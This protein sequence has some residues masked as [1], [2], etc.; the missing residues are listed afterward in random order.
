[1]NKQEK[2]QIYKIALE[3]LIVSRDIAKNAIN[4]IKE[5]GPS[6]ISFAMAVEHLETA[7]HLTSS[8]INDIENGKKK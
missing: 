4:K 5:T 1:M 8:W 7:I 3:L 6:G 2:L